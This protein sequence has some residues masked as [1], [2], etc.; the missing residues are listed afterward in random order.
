M[1]SA[2]RI[3]DK[4]VKNPVEMARDSAQKSAEE[5]FQGAAQLRDAATRGVTEFTDTARRV[6]GKAADPIKDELMNS[7]LDRPSFASRRRAQN[8]N[9]SGA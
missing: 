2:D 5:I 7:P 9:C 1:Q 6:F 8:S 4:N 3:L